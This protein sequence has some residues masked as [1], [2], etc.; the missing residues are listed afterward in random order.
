MKQP[1][2]PSAEIMDDATALLLPIIPGGDVF[3][4]IDSRV[5]ISDPEEVRLWVGR[6]MDGRRVVGTLAGVIELPRLVP[7]MTKGQLS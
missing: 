6:T 5:A 2:F 4:V 7:E 1:L 3:R